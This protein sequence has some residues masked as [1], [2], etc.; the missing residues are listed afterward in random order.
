MGKTTKRNVHQAFSFK[1][2]KSPVT[3]AWERN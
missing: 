2:S 1:I 3:A